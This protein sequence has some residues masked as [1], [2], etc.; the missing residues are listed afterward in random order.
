MSHAMDEARPTSKLLIVLF[1]LYA[2][3]PLTWGVVNTLK[4]ALKLFQ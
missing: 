4:E 1:W 2:L 3:I